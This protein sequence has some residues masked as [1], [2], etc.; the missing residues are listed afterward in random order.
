MHENETAMQ[1]LPDLLLDLDTMEPSVRLLALIQGVLA[2]NIFDWGSRECV[3]KY[4]DGLILSI[5]RD[6]R[7]RLSKRPWRV[8]DFDKLSARWLRCEE[9]KDGPPYRRVLI[10]ADNAGADIVLGL[11]PLARELLRMGCD[12]VFAANTLPAIN[13]IT[14]EELVDVV[15]EASQYCSILSSAWKAGN[16]I[17]ARNRGNIPPFENSQDLSDFGSSSEH[18]FPETPAGHTAD[19][20]TSR[21]FVA[22]SGQV[23]PCLD[24]RCVGSNVARAAVGT[25]LVIIEG[26]GRAIHTNLKTQLKCDCLKLA[27]IK[28][29][30][31]ASSLFGGDLFDCVCIYDTKPKEDV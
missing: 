8:D 31:L 4:Q 13:D 16:R 6:A 23:S 18:S 27:M 19:E 28:N 9:G 14:V 10:F 7:E 29:K 1:V 5:Y 17:R 26:M 2:A 24:L 22:D 20:P 15:E 3:A 30:H 12:V 25:D 11:I 21:L